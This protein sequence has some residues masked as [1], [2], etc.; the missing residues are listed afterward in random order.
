M[1]GVPLMV[2]VLVFIVNPGGKV[3]VNEAKPP[4]LDGVTGVIAVPIVKV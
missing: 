1:V 3:A 4:E 2:P